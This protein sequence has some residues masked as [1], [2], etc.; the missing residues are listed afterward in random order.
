MTPPVTLSN[1]V[2]SVF[3]IG[4]RPAETARNA[5]DMV[6]TGAADFGRAQPI[7]IAAPLRVFAASGIS[8]LNTASADRRIEP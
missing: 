8:G 4:T 2:N 7:R 6:L 5:P 1:A 3:A